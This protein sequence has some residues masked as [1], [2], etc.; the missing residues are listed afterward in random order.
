MVSDVAVGLSDILDKVAEY[1]SDADASVVM[2]AYL[3]SARAHQGQTRKSGEDY[4]IHPIAVA[5]ILADLRMDVDTIA[6]G[7]LHDTMEDCLSTH[8]EI[9]DEFGGDVADMV[10]GVTKIGKLEFRTQHE[11][12]AENFRKLVLAM[13]N[14][15]RVIL[16]KL[17]DRLHNMRT[18]TH[19]KP[20]KA[21]AISQ[22]TMEI[23]APIA[24]RLGLSSL[25]MELEDLCLRYLHPEIH[26]KLEENLAATSEERDAY[27]ERAGDELES[28]LGEK[29]IIAAVKGRPKHLTSIWRKMRTR[30]LAFEELF[31]VHA[32]RLFVDSVGD[33]YTAL[34]YIHGMYRHI[35]ER[36]KDYIANPKSNGYQSLH[37]AVLGPEGQ[38]I[39]V[40]IR[41]WDMHRVAEV[42]IAA[43]WRYK[44]GHLTLSR[45][46]LSKLSQ[47]RGIFEAAREVE[48]PGEFLETVKVDLFAEE[49]FVFTPR[50]DVYFFPQGATVLDFAY[51]IHTRVGDTCTGALVNGRMS[52]LH[53]EL[54]SGDRVDI[55]RKSD[56]KPSRA[57]LDI[58]KTGRALSKIRRSVREKERDAGRELGKEMVE[59]ELKKRGTTLS[60]VTKEGLLEQAA[61]QFSLHNVEQVFL[62]VGSGNLT[63]VKVMDELAPGTEPEAERPGWRSWFSRP[64]KRSIS[65]VLI[66]G[67]S[68]LLVNFAK[69]CSPL[70]GE[71][72]MGFIT[73]GRGITVHLANCTQLMASD[74][75]RRIPVAWHQ[76]ASGAHTGEI[77]I[78]TANTPGM[79][80]EVGGICK[81]LSINVTRLE[82]KE[83]DRG[84][85][86]F[87]L[88]V[89][90]VD[91]EQLVRLMRNLEKIDGVLRVDRVRALRV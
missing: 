49:V 4:L 55:V 1:S 81:S 91:V 31:D 42:G 15:V 57:W 62:A 54:R 71:Q 13:A 51:A 83:V 78:V 33:C 87:T 35:P 45:D 37:T 76:G 39:E 67:Q 34:G 80:A 52:P 11:A 9:A 58:A 40:Q 53:R 72:V 63:M 28:K 22:E 19:M 43:H 21:R 79:L 32:F 70:P 7:L 69:C 23:Y 36:L 60:K 47:L 46:D 41:T 44:E 89:N 56:Q 38:P 6:V 29:G 24:N 30:N 20:E 88:S 84:R 82:A 59:A 74:S 3:Y 27:I 8:V 64:K 17:A 66:D 90:V 10:D 65:P 26:E 85:A 68:D 18:M 25:K 16:V 61:Q 48:D 86:E 77:R 50:G 12:Q 5:G 75:E 73:R 14:D 2:R